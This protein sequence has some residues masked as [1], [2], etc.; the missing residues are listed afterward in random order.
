MFELK[1][2]FWLMLVVAVVFTFF[3]WFI[4]SFIKGPP[5]V[6]SER[7]VVVSCQ[8]HEYF[9]GDVCDE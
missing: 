6:D 5:A 3:L 1:V 7:D 2:L 9:Q 8:L 4:P